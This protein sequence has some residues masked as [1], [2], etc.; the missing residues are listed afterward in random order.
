MQSE[1][2]RFS[3]GT[4]AINSPGNGDSVRRVDVELL[5]R[6]RLLIAFALLLLALNI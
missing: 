5:F 4:T 6:S 2:L 3:R 1:S